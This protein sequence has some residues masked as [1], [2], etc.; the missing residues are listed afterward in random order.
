MS[1]SDITPILLKLPTNL[2]RRIDSKRATM[3]C[4]YSIK[5]R[6]LHRSEAI[7]MAIEEWLGPELGQLDIEDAIKEKG[8]RG[9]VAPARLDCEVPAPRSPLPRHRAKSHGGKAVVK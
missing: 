1:K 6:S 8:D 4:K 9:P 2:L 7:V 3:P 5:D